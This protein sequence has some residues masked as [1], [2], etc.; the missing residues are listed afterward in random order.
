MN[1]RMI[2]MLLSLVLELLGLTPTLIDDIEKILAELHS[3]DPTGTK[4]SNIA[5]TAATLA[6][7]AGNVLNNANTSGGTGSG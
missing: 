3:A 2:K 5:A 7:A 4:V 1:L 6:T